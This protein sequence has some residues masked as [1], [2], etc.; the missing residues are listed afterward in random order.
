MSWDFDTIVGFSAYDY[1]RFEPAPGGWVRKRPWRDFLSKVSWL[2][3]YDGSATQEAVLNDPEVIEW[4]SN[5]KPGSYKPRLWG[6]TREVS[7]LMSQ[8]E[9]ATGKPMKR[10][11]IPGQALADQKKVNKLKGTL[12]RIGVH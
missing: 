9:V 8:I 1:F 6:H 4:M 11:I 7:L 3:E 10:P 12:S 5:Q 2:T